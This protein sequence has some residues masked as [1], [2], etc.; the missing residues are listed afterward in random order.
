M[1]ISRSPTFSQDYDFNAQMQSFDYNVLAGKTNTTMTVQSQQA[2]IFNI[3][4]SGI[5]G[6]AKVNLAVDISAYL[7]S[8]QAQS[9][10]KPVIYISDNTGIAPNYTG[11][12]VVLTSTVILG[13]SVLI[14][15]NTNGTSSY[16][17]DKSFV[18]ST[19]SQLLYRYK[20]YV[21]IKYYNRTISGSSTANIQILNTQQQN[22]QANGSLQISLSE[23]AKPYL[24]LTGCFS[25][26]VIVEE[27]DFL[28]SIGS[29]TS[30]IFN[31]V[32]SSLTQQN[33]GNLTLFNPND[34]GKLLPSTGFKLLY[35]EGKVYP[36]YINFVANNNI[37]L[38]TNNYITLLINF[39]NIE[40]DL[41]LEAEVDI[42]SQVLIGLTSVDLSRLS[43]SFISELNDLSPYK[44]GVSVK[45]SG[46]NSGDF[47]PTDFVPTDW[48]TSDE[49]YSSISGEFKFLCEK[50]TLDNPRDFYFSFNSG[51]GGLS[52]FLCKMYNKM[53][54]PEILQLR[55]RDK[56]ANYVSRSS[57]FYDLTMKYLD[58]KEMLF[59]TG[60]DLTSSSKQDAVYESEQVIRTDQFGVQTN[61]LMEPATYE[62]NNTERFKDVAFTV[63]RP[64]F[65]NSISVE[66]PTV[67]ILEI[68]ATST[69][70]TITCQITQVGIEPVLQRGV[71]ILGVLYQQATASNEYTVE[72]TGLTPSTLYSVQAR[73]ASPTATINSLSQNFTTL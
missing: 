34:G 43:A 20:N 10:V 60:T 41:L 16:Q 63:V 19:T 64:N 8:V 15:E 37:N 24:P 9:G 55:N 36:F 17:G 28:A 5:G 22:L 39:Y 33:Y 59:L 48:V 68:V 65:S 2:Q 66:E 46:F 13:L 4:N 73:V 62:Q 11:S 27:Y 29:V 50:Y 31:F 21:T 23:P 70:A 32:N 1:I 45:Y 35:N 42:S 58:L 26:Q 7:T 54:E 14:V 71:V 30:D 38:F 47:D 53:S 57:E 67:S 69:T 52:T 18:G 40:E 51:W 3:Q 25:L 44:I 72:V 12:Y 56:L 49:Y 61:W 6:N